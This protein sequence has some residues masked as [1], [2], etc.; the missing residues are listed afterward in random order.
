MPS[1]RNHDRLFA[2]VLAELK[3][4]WK[5]GSRLNLTTCCCD[6]WLRCHRLAFTGA[7]GALGSQKLADRLPPW[8]APGS[9]GQHQRLVTSS[10]W[11]V[12]QTI[13][14]Q[15][16]RVRDGRGCSRTPFRADLFA[17]RFRRMPPLLLQRDQLLEELDRAR[18]VHIRFWITDESVDGLTFELGDTA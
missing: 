13:L 4:A 18:R 11:L 5:D 10:S 16:Q 12:R 1:V 14:H 3:K 15:R 2:R 8:K 6:S 7:F 17:G 9:I